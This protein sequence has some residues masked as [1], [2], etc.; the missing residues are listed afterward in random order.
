LAS[1]GLLEALVY[2]FICSASIEAELGDRY[3][4]DCDL[5]KLPL[6]EGGAPVDPDAVSKLRDTMTSNVGVVR[7]AAG[8]RRALVDIAALEA[9]NHPDCDAF[10]NMTATATLIAA[11][12][13]LREE[14]R[15]GHYRD[16]F[17]D[18]VDALAHRSEIT[19]DDAIALRSQVVKED[20]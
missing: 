19:L 17:P 9:A 16:D 4:E 15:G 20:A 13:L 1:N 18:A 6:V 10:L 12:A 3:E 5:V 7:N 2:A 14:S 11:S 8:L